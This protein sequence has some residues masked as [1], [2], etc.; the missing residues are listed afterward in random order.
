MSKRT[1]VR[2]LL[3]LLAFSLTIRFAASGGRASKALAALS[4]SELV[5]RVATGYYG[6]LETPET[7][8][9]ETA[10]P[11]YE[12]PPESAA[13]PSPLPAAKLPARVLKG[14]GA[15]SPK[16][17]AASSVDLL[18]KTSYEPD[19]A[20]LLAEGPGFSLAEEGPQILIVHTH[21]SE[22]Y[23]GS[24]GSRS[25][26]PSQGVVRVGDVLAGELAARGFSVL[27]DRTMYDLPTYS[28]SY[29]RSLEAVESALE[30]YPE[31]TV[32]IDL[33]RDSVT[34]AD[35]TKWRSAYGGDSS[36]VM[37]IATNGENGL[38]HPNWLEN[39]RFALRLQAAME[40]KF[41][42]LARPLVLS[43]ERYNQHAAP[44]C[45]ILEVGTDG[46]SLA[47]AETAVRSFA[48][49]AADVLDGMR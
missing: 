49:A 38:E 12:Y 39:F 6:P 9:A 15:G 7:P 13:P 2:V 41:P 21:G 34:L 25:T 37:L 24:E 35:G 5:A 18:N 17:P 20:A 23:S 47:E 45:L 1:L 16:P 30:K 29:A 43:G 28:G 19:V 27:H 10:V 46:N 42:G 48:D 4:S 3:G 8:R 44:G 32:V 31:L 14:D 40:E 26:D 36:Q 22:A 33:H 11:E